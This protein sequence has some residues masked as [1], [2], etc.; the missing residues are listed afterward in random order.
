[1]SPPSIKRGRASGVPGPRCAARGRTRPF[2]RA[3]S[4]PPGRT[5]ASRT[6]SRGGCPDW[7]QRDE[8]GSRF[9]E[10]AGAETERAKGRLEVDV[11]PCAARRAAPLG[12]GTDEGGSHAVATA[13]LCHHGVQHEG[14]D[15]AVPGDIDEPDQLR[16]VPCTHPPETVP[17]QPAPPVRPPDRAPE[18]LACR[19]F[20]ARMRWA[21]W[22]RWPAAPATGSPRRTPASAC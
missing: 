16:A 19:A 22:R 12:G 1:M 17:L 6:A 10:P 4:A 8:S 18:P 3:R 13:P 5:S 14:V 2:S 21:R 9:P 15:P 7:S 11:E 20:R